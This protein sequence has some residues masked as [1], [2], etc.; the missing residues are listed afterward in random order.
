VAHRHAGVQTSGTDV[1]ELHGSGA[2]LRFPPPSVE[3][4]DERPIL[5]TRINDNRSYSKVLL[6]G[7]LFV[8][9]A[10]VLGFHSAGVARRRTAARASTMDSLEASSSCTTSP[11]GR[12]CR[13]GRSVCSRK[14][15]S[16]TRM[17]S[18]RTLSRYSSAVPS[19]AWYRAG[20]SVTINAAGC[21]ATL[22]HPASPA[23]RRRPADARHRPA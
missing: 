21:A 8:L 10:P 20:P 23:S 11:E 3:D 7:R 14:G 18:G 15:Q 9:R 17:L 12:G 4:Q 6:Q 5:S 13:L 1:E 16:G 19:T 2:T 22:R